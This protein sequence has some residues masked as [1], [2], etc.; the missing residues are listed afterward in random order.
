MLEGVTNRTRLALL[1]HVTSPTGLVFPLGRLIAELN[2]RGVDTL[3]DG[4]HASVTVTRIEGE[5]LV[6]RGRAD[7]SILVNMAGLAG[8]LQSNPMAMALLGSMFF[9][10]QETSSMSFPLEEQWDVHPEHEHGEDW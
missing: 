5:N 2:E 8:G 6:Q 9:T 1:D 10:A 4:A 7:S 3:V